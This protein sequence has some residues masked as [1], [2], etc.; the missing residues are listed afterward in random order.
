MFEVNTKQ[1]SITTCVISG[2]GSE[3][4]ENCAVLGWYAA[5]GSNFLPTFRDNLS[6]SIIRVK[7]FKRIWILYT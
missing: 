5:S 7:E 6:G 2:F 4:D 1:N 3:V